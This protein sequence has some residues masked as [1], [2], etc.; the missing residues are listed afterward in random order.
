M[1]A[2]RADDQ[3]L[4]CSPEEGGGRREEGQSTSE[5]RTEQGREEVK[6]G[7]E[8]S[9]CGGRLNEGKDREREVQR[10]RGEGQSIASAWSALEGNG[11]ITA[12]RSPLKHLP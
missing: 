1:S 6:W 7:K 8:K 2:C 12:S 3:S 10:G 9:R 11:E 5:G 4:L